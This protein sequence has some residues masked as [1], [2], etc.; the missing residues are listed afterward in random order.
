MKR[1]IIL[2]LAFIVLLGGSLLADEMTTAKVKVAAANVRSK[3]DASAPIVA[4]VTMGTVLEVTGKEG[5]W[6]EVNVN[7]QSGKEVSGYIHN[8]VVE[9]SGEEGEER[10]MNIRSAQRVVRRA[11]AEK[12]Y[13]PGGIKLMGGLSLGNGTLSETLPPEVKKTS[14]MGFMGGLGFESGGMVAFETDL[15]YSPG[16][17]VIKSADPA[18]TGK[19]TI[20]AN[21]VTLPIMVK[22]RFL[23]GTTPY[24]LAG[25]E[26]GY[27]LNAKVILTASDGSTNEEDAIE[28]INRLIYGVVFGGGVEMQAGGM[29]LLLEARY[30]LGL[31]NLVKDA[32]PGE[33]M[34]PTALTFL[35][36]VKF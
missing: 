36:G 26:I 35:L 13:A 30:R 33:Y 3:P 10:Q 20:A 29:N 4:K 27:I 23:R 14:R 1:N 2:A 18:N 24:I 28:D 22:V 16:G 25:G 8:T 11:S 6:Y 31:S 15:L 34:K 19:I 7:D 32:D 21:A 12:D 9:I 17:V 5:A